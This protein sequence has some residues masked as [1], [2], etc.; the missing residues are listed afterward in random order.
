MNEHREE[1]FIYRAEDRRALLLRVR[2]NNE[3]IE[4]YNGTDEFIMARRDITFR[5]TLL[6]GVT[7]GRERK[8]F[9]FI[10]SV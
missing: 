8:Q 6:V 10:R 2:Y 7:P 5:L 1:I 9:Y 3:L 4:N